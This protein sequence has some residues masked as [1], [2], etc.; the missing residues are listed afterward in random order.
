MN[1]LPAIR[2]NTIDRPEHKGSVRHLIAD[3]IRQAF[4]EDFYFKFNQSFNLSAPVESFADK[5]NPYFGYYGFRWHPINFQPNYF[6]VGIDISEVIGS[7]IQA[8]YEGH[9]EYAGY[10]NINGNYIVVMHPSIKTKDGFVFQSLY[11]H[12][13]DLN[14]KF[15]LAQKILREY[16]SKTIKIANTSIQ[17]KQI[18][19]TVGDTGNKLGVVP[20]LHLQFEF[21]KGN[22]HIVVDPLKIFGKPTLQNLTASISTQA[23]F[24]SF[25]YAHLNELLPW[26]KFWTTKM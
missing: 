21:V 22:E 5:I 10:A 13:K 8:V 1:T 3:P 18:I 4:W 15:N 19:A 6:H 11:L 26:K 7:P 2:N 16:F 9:L 24:R 17:N 20:H 14:L 12:C 25:Y 23:E